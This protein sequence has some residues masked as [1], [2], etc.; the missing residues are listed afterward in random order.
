MNISKHQFQD[1]FQIDYKINW[2]DV[3][4]DIKSA[5]DAGYNIIILSFYLQRSGLVDAALSFEKLPSH[6]Q[7]SIINY[8]HLHGAKIMISAGG[9]TEHVDHMLLDTI[10]LDIAFSEGENYARGAADKVNELNL[11]GIDFDI[12]LLPQNNQ[13]FLNGRMAQFVKGTIHG[14]RKYLKNG[15]AIVTARSK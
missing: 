3:T 6:K 8:A 14:A 13:P 10:P 4:T 5:V 7:E 12:E 15:D 2:S 1:I 11:D 9:A